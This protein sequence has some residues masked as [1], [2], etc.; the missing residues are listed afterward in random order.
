MRRLWWG[1][2]VVAA[3]CAPQKGGEPAGKAEEGPAPAPKAGGDPLVAEWKKV[4][5]EED[6]RLVIGEG[7]RGELRAAYPLSNWFR[8]QWK[9]PLRQS[10]GAKADENEF[11]DR[12]DALEVSAHATIPFEVRRPAA[13]ELAFQLGE[14][15]TGYTIPDDFLAYV[16]RVRGEE[17]RKEVAAMREAVDRQAKELGGATARAEQARLRHV[18]Y[19]FD[20]LMMRCWDADR[21]DEKRATLYR[22]Q[23]D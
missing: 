2:L 21:G 19:K 13:D 5:T 3:G 4:S 9:G 10:F 20:F 1:L 14:P 17:G 8:R 16:V 6:V 18:K 11:E 23:V 15:R 22:K 7:G 12:F